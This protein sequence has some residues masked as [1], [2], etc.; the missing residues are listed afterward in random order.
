MRRTDGR[1]YD[2]HA[3]R[4]ALFEVEY[5]RHI[6]SHY[7]VEKRVID[8]FAWLPTRMNN[9]TL[10]WLKKF[11]IVEQF[12]STVNEKHRIL[13]QMRYTES[14]YIERKLKGLVD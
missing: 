1:L 3:A 4:E 7:D 11:V 9:G 5:L 6:S 12:Y 14:D 8:Q 2:A 13:H 10:I